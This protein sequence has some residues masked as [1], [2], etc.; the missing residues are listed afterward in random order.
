M[1]FSSTQLEQV[2]SWDNAQ[3]E[4]RISPDLYSNAAV[5]LISHKEERGH[6]QP[7][8]RGHLWC[9]VLR[10]LSAELRVIVSPSC[11]G[12]LQSH[13]PLYQWRQEV[14]QGPAS[15]ERSKDDHKHQHKEM[16][17]SA[18]AQI[19]RSTS[20]IPCITAKCI[21]CLLVWQPKHLPYW[22]QGDSWSPLT[23]LHKTPIK[24]CHVETSIL[25]KSNTTT[26]FPVQ[27]H[28]WV[29]D[30]WVKCKLSL[31]L[32]AVAWGCNHQATMCLSEITRGLVSAHYTVQSSHLGIKNIT[33][34]QMEDKE[35]FTSHYYPS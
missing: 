12:W 22:C 4:S 26:L 10:L 8:C 20:Y 19:I 23:E 34:F 9:L 31:K 27:M 16:V 1:D 7:L 32:Q 6:M 13:V 5:P 30:S 3:K 24:I 33:C 28:G 11:P 17:L 18:C 35:G 21:P 29:V 2:Q 15:W 14:C 25:T